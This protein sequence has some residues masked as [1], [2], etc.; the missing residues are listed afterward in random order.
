MSL[1][2][3]GALLFRDDLMYIPWEDNFEIQLW[4]NCSNQRLQNLWHEKTRP[5]SLP[6]IPSPWRIPITMERD[7]MICVCSVYFYIVSEEQLSAE[8][9]IYQVQI[10]GKTVGGTI[11]FTNCQGLLRVIHSENTLMIR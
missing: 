3:F 11:N 8:R 1:I 5:S 7:L 2:V 4:K 9:E 10:I 6:N